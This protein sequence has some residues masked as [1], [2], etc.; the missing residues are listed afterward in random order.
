MAEADDTWTRRVEALHTGL[1]RGDHA[2]AAEAA[3]HLSD[4]AFRRADRV[5]EAWLS[6][7][8]DCRGLL[9][10]R[11]DQGSGAGIWNYKDSAADLYCHL[12]IEASLLAP[13][14]LPDLRD[15][16]ARE[17]RI[18]DGVP[19]AVRLDSGEPLSQTLEQ[20]I[21]GAVE[22]AKDGRLPILERVGPT[23]WLQRLHEVVDAILAAAPVHTRHGRLPCDGTEKNGEM[24][25]VL[26][27]LYHRDRRSEHL[28]AGRAI[29]DAYILDVLPANGGLPAA[30]WDFATGMA[31]EVDLRLRDHGNEIFAGLVEW[32][33]A[34]SVAP[35][36]RCELYR[37]AVE[38]MLDLLLARGRR[39]SGMWLQFLADEG[40]PPPDEETALNDNWG[41]LTAVYVAHA[42]TLPEGAPGRARYLE[43]ARRA[44]Q[45]AIQHHGANW[46]GPHFDGYADAIEGALYLLPFLTPSPPAAERAGGWGD[47]AAAARWIDEE[48]GIL[49]AYQ[50]GDG[51]VGR[52]YLD[53]NY[54][55]TALLYGLFRTAG[56]RVDPWRPGVRLGAIP[57][58]G[59][60]HLALASDTAWSGKL[61][62]DTVR[63]R[64]HLHLPFDY[65]RLNGW[66]EWFTTDPSAQWQMERRTGAQEP[67][68]RTVAGAELIAG[69]S[70]DLS[71]GAPVHLRL[72]Q[73]T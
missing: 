6:V 69:I 31:D 63:H 46:E 62:I 17:R 5:V 29:A 44:L 2:A 53:G 73:S 20:R 51:F 67:E 10:R 45:A 19:V 9:P 38:R 50:G 64:E 14:H 39:P 60:I 12:V 25:Q 8:D 72:T 68:V 3:G 32:T 71:P 47:Q 15:I 40:A 41:Y 33:I 58:G 36:S 1:Q 49:L 11:L 37:P 54:V 24:L 26:A 61:L 34:E 55:R 66:P 16:L 35:D 4:E 56:A 59:G 52:T 28:A 23:E 13:R 48:T 27:R 42:L 18:S 70:L 7:R 43:E 30:E 22:Y 65:P 57:S 21:F